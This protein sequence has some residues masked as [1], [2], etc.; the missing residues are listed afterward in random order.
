MQ[1]GCKQEFLIVR[2]NVSC[3]VKDLEAVKK[4]VALGMML[5]VLLDRFQRLE[6]HLVD[7]ESVEGF[8]KRA[9]RGAGSGSGSGSARTV[10][11]RARDRARSCSR[12][13]ESEGRSPGRSRWPSTAAA[14]RLAA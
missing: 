1:E 3:Q 9:D 6:P 2:A 13:S 5:G 8:G 4:G 12:T 14:F 7:G 11:R 10:F